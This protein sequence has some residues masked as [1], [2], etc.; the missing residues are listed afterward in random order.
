MRTF[1]LCML[2][3]LILVLARAA[4]G[5]SPDRPWLPEDRA[6]LFPSPEILPTETPRPVLP[7]AETLATIP[8]ESRTQATATGTSVSQV[9]ANPYPPPGDLWLP[10]EPVPTYTPDATDYAVW[11]YW[12]LFT[13]EPYPEP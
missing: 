6:A 11:E 10:W 13:P 1:S 12:A 7:A 5:A 4:A 2:I 9:T 3:V 8:Q